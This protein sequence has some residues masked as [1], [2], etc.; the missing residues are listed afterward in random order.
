MSE[1][2]TSPDDVREGFDRDVP[3]SSDEYVLGLIR[4]AERRLARRLGPLVEWAHTEARREDVRDVVSSMVQRV[5]R[6]DGSI[7]K[8]ES[9]GDY[10]YTR[11][12]LAASANLWVTDDEWAQLVG[13]SG[14]GVGTMRIG[15]PSWSPRAW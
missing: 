7:N 8:S 14:P 9:D 13:P 6:N 12:P 4:K 3:G 11:D 2:I 5:L 1:T 15:L 10:S